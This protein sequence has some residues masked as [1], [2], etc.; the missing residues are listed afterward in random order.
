ML[1][2]VNLCAELTCRCSILASFWQAACK[3]LHHRNS[4]PTRGNE[5]PWFNELLNKIN[6]I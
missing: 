2:V 1:R 5:R 3:A 4:E 6:V